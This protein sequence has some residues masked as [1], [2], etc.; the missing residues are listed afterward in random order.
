MLIEYCLAYLVSL[1]ALSCYLFIGYASRLTAFMPAGTA[2]SDNSSSLTRQERIFYA[3]AWPAYFSVN[4]V[5]QRLSFM[6]RAVFLVI[7]LALAVN[8]IQPKIMSLDP[9]RIEQALVTADP[10]FNEVQKHIDSLLAIYPD[11]EKIAVTSLGKDRKSSLVAP[12]HIL[13]P[14]AEE[15]AASVH[16][17]LQA[18][19]IVFR[20]QLQ[21]GLIA[22]NSPPSFS[23]IHYSR[24]PLDD[25][26]AAVT[27]A[28]VLE[29]CG[30]QPYVLCLKTSW[31]T[32]LFRP[33]ESSVTKVYL[34]KQNDK[35]G[36]ISMLGIS[37]PKFNTLKELAGEL[38]EKM[39][40]SYTQYLLFDLNV[41]CPGW[42]KRNP[43]I[44]GYEI[45]RN[46]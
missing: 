23:Q 1:L 34:Y 14:A 31:K 38:S 24:R 6:A 30:Y 44:Q 5:G 3:V 7:V 41:A 4:R 27:A 37:E 16:H 43:G 20:Y 46:L 26:G 12:E 11:W 28:Y 8:L 15:V 2:I 17:P 45:W 21:N 10:K 19:I 22:D 25:Y 13:A 18:R 42:H 32:F 29:H 36:Y 40:V 39:H 35:F 9:D 33:L